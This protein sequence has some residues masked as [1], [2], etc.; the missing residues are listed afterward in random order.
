MNMQICA[1]SLSE[2]LPPPDAR[3]SEYDE[4]IFCRSG[5]GSLLIGGRLT[6]VREGD[7]LEIPAGLPH[8]A[9]DQ[10]AETETLS[11]ESREPSFG[12]F[13]SLRDDGSFAVLFDLAM[14]A[15]R[16]G[17]PYWMP[18]AYGLGNMMLRLLLCIS[19]DANSR[20]HAAVIQL[21][22]L[23]Q[24]CSSDPGFD[25]SQAIAR[26]G[27]SDGYMRQLFRQAYGMPPQAYLCRMRVGYAKALLRASRRDMT[28]KQIS[29]RAGFRDPYY[30]SRMFRKLEGVSPTE[31]LDQL[32]KAERGAE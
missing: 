11:F 29:Q 20:T 21:E 9:V 26:T 19:A 27:Y 30:F 16:R 18:Y 12:Y 14:D 10:L 6:D 22:R 28:V 3:Q 4:V 32:D 24:Q 7:L 1:V 5:S 17:G 8:S 13:L 15:L 31:Y 23:I 25:L 2:L